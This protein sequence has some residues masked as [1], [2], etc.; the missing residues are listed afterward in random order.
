[1]AVNLVN[2]LAVLIVEVAVQSKGKHCAVNLVF[3]RLSVKKI[4]QVLRT[5]RHET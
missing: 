2:F 3:Y 5:D 4:E 1:M